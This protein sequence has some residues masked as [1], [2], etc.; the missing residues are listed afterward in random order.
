MADSDVQLNIKKL[1]EFAETLGKASPY[2]KVGV[3]GTKVQRT[4][5]KK[6]LTMT[7]IV[8]M[9][10]KLKPKA[11]NKPP[12]NNV[13][14]GLIHE[15]GSPKRGIPKRSFL[16][17]PLTTRLKKAMESAGAFKDATIAK[18]IEDKTLT[19]WI[20]K[21]GVLAEGVVLEAFATGGFGKW[22]AWK[23]KGYTNNANM[24]LVDTTQLRNSISHEVVGGAG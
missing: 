6:V 22:P 23:R 8:N 24:L 18:V 17:M 2:V 21:I 9:R 15:F 11:G 3:M 10:T 16:M 4:E 12:L 20:S 7:E 19:P 5:N 13:E 1:V 14:I